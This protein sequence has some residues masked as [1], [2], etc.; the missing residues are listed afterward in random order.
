MAIFKLPESRTLLRAVTRVDRPSIPA[1]PHGSSLPAAPASRQ[2]ALAPSSMRPAGAGAAAVQALSSPDLHTKMASSPLWAQR[3][4]FLTSLP[5][6]I[7]I[8]ASL[9]SIAHVVRDSVAGSFLAEPVF[10]HR[11]WLEWQTCRAITTQTVRHF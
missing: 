5:T 11:A 3:V 1:L 4:A 8:Q 10:L 2:I 6:L 9:F 7:Q